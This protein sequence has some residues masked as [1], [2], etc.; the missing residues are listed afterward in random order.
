MNLSGSRDPRLVVLTPAALADDP[1][2][3][4]AVAAAVARGLVVD[5]ICT[6]RGTAPV[7]ESVNVVE[8]GGGSVTRQLRTA[9][10]GGMTRSGP[11]MRE[12]RGI[13]RL[14]RLIALTLRLA[15]AARTLPRPDVVHAND[16]D[17]LLAAVLIGRREARVV[18][19]AH[20]LYA[21]QEPDPPRLHRA[22][23]RRLERVLVRRASAVITVN[24]PIA[25]ELQVLHHLQRAPLVVLNCPPVEDVPVPELDT[26][27]R[28]IYQGA[29][30]PGRSVAD[31]IEAAAGLAGVRLTIRV[32]GA[33]LDLLAGAVEARGLEEVVQ[34]VEPVTPH[35]L[36]QALAGFDVGLVINRP[37][38]RNDTL[39]LPNK[40]FEY[41]MAG[42][43]VV[44]P[45]LPALTELIEREQIGVTYE[46][47]SP[48]DLARVL[49]AL[50]RSPE[51]V[52]KMRVCAYRAAR[53]RFNAEAQAPA[54][55]RAWGL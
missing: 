46:P 29:M 49:N 1:R 53:D 39:V 35:D 2:G 12:F 25:D 23:L 15:R 9:G 14:A 19:D 33:D 5:V 10:L 48:T 32:A 51:D 54:L 55:H 31:L 38:T 30:G 36:V 52:L 47:G 44:A 3:L 40:V 28:V 43:A 4:R 21:D 26:Y 17:T 45:R 50:A 20:E 8:V 6:T 27:L 13:F 41:L 34:V 16:L 42:L 24:E 7:P 37:V 11:V 22:V 18:Y